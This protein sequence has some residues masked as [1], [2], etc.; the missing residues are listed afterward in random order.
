MPMYTFRCTTCGA[1]QEVV[2]SI[3]DYPE[4]P[5]ARCRACLGEM[6]R[7]YRADRPQ[8]APMWPEHLN[9]STG[10]VV[11]SRKQLQDDMNRKADEQFERTGIPSRPVVVDRADMPTFQAPDPPPRRKP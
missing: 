11:R 3:R 2:S 6:V 9:P 10:T 1:R 5:N 7:D 8:P 4:R